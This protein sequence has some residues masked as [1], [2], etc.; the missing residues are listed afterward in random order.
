MFERVETPPLQCLVGVVAQPQ[1]Y[2][3]IAYLLLGLPLGTAWFTVLVAGFS[4]AASMVVVALL[5]IP[6]LVGIWH[7]CRLFANAER[8]VASVLLGRHIGSASVD[9][10]MRGNLWRRLRS[11]SRERNRQRELSFLMLR[12]PVGIAT[13][14]A[15]ATAISTPVLIALVPFRMRHV[16]DHPFG[17]WALSSKL[18]TFAQSSWSWSLV[19][20]G[21]AMFLAAFH[22]MNALADACGRWTEA[23]LGI[24][25]AS[26]GSSGR[27]GAVGNEQFREPARRDSESSD[28]EEAECHTEQVGQ[29]ASRG[30]AI[31][32]Q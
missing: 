31:G 29:A 8:Q 5:G 6:M 1:S 13:F 32:T 30:K 9:L 24:D 17:T 2:R 3:N 21:I 19:P 15:A 10:Q 7:M 20:V 4:S 28:P 16:R 27:G 14:V 26:C 23:W 22:A 11:M 12:F 18:E 25:R